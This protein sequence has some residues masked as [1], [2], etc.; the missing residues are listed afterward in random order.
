M[1][2]NL[3]TM[4]VENQ[5]IT[6][7]FDTPADPYLVREQKRA[8]LDIL[9]AVRIIDPR[10]VVAGGAARNWYFQRPARDIDIYI[11]QVQN[12]NEDVVL[13]SS[14]I[15][16]LLTTPCGFK[17]VVMRNLSTAEYGTMEGL[18]DVFSTKYNEI[19]FD[20]IGID[21]DPRE[22]RQTFDSTISMCMWNPHPNLV[23][24][25]EVLENEALDDI[26]LQW[27]GDTVEL[28]E[29]QIIYIKHG[30]KQS[31]YDKHMLMF[32]D[33]SLRVVKNVHEFIEEEIPF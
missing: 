26:P 15:E 18:R 2:Q 12:K 14:Q 7:L 20:I 24:S 6:S 21:G 10:A 8:A 9:R 17:G 11:Q 16:A 19:S 3:K 4:L 28:I 32:P 30:T 25:G 1:A 27:Y 29:K 31:R 13:R 33:F 22:V 5:A 23:Y